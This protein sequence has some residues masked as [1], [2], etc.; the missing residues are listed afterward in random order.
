MEAT[1]SIT[2]SASDLLR[3]IMDGERDFDRTRIPQ[4]Q[5]NLEST[6]G[7]QA[8]LSYLKE[9]DM[10]AAPIKAEGADW[11]GLRAPDLQLSFSKM[12]GANL[13]GA[14]LQRAEFRR[15]D[16]SEV[17][18]SGADLRGAVLIGSNLQRSNLQGAIVRGGDM[19][20]AGLAGANLRDADFT[21]AALPRLSAKGADFTNANLTNVLLYRTDLRGALGLD[22]ARDLGVANF[23]R[24]IVTNVEL[25]IIQQAITRRLNFELHE[26]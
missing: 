4:D 22:A 23:H 12:S 2:I 5:A 26:E 17:N 3:R 8:L 18:L 25:A 21:G 19:Y 1:A 11:H 24:T 20:E 9:Q 10:R 13:A 14:V 15:A 16:L 7:Y 6:D